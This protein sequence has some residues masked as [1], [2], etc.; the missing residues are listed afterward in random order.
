MRVDSMETDHI[1]RPQ[2]EIPLRPAH[3][4]E[5]TERELETHEQCSDDTPR[6][7]I[8]DS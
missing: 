5:N 2:F 8:G 4:N 3:A 7:G 6:R 1:H